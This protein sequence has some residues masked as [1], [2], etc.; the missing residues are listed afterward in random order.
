MQIFR[1]NN[2]EN[3]IKQDLPNITSYNSKHS[4]SKITKKSYGIV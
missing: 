1:E 2:F 4:T 3:Q